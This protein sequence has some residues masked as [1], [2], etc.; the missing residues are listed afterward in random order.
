MTT[1]QRMVIMPKIN[2]FHSLCASLVGG[3]LILKYHLCVCSCVRTH[4]EAR[5]QPWRLLLRCHHLI[6]FEIGFLLEPGAPSASCPANPDHTVRLPS[7]EATDTCPHASCL[8]RRWDGTQVL[9]P[10][11]Q[12]HYYYFLHWLGYK[13]PGFR[14][15][16]GDIIWKFNPRQITIHT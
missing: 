13:V 8:C 16:K 6:Y 15:E 3:P 9:V 11:P 10:T 5:D 2:M 14:E 7:T 12:Y 1:L 4:I